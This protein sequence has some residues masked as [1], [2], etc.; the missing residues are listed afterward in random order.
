MTTLEP[1]PHGAWARAPL[2]RSVTY[3]A[4]RRLR[5]RTNA[6]MAVTRSNAV[7]ER[8]LA[9]LLPPAKDVGL[10]IATCG[11]LGPASEEEGG[12]AGVGASTA[13][14]VLPAIKPSR[15]ATPGAPS[16]PYTCVPSGKSRFGSPM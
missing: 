11:V 8:E 4:V 5:R 1:S 10:V 3:L 15:Y 16:V 2:R 7:G 13:A 9:Q 14:R 6:A 12:G